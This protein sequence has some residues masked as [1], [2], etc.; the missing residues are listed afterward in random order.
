[1]SKGVNWQ[2]FFA[3]RTQKFRIDI[4]KENART[5][6]I[7]LLG[8]ETPFVTNEDASDNFFAPIRPQTGTISVCTK[9]ERQGAYPLGGTLKLEDIIPEN[10]IDR[11]VKVWNIT[12]PSSPYLEWQGFL[13]CEVYSQEYT[14]IPQ[15]IDLPVISVL[16]AMDSV[17]VE[18]SESMAFQRILSHCIYAMKAIETKS[19]M[20][21]FNTVFLD[22][23]CQYET[24]ANYFYNNVYFDADEQISGDNIVVEVH[25][26][27][28]KAIL[29]QVAKFFGCCWREASGQ[30]IYF[31]AVGKTAF[32]TYDTFTNIYNSLIAGTSTLNLKS[33]NASTANLSD[34]KW[35]GNGH[36][37]SVTQG[38]RRV[39]V[40]SKL[41]D[42]E[43]KMSLEE[44]P[45]NDL[46]ENPEARQSANGEVHVNTN[47][48]FYSLADHKHYLTRAIFP[49][50]LSG[51]S[52][53]LTSTLS[54][55]NYAHTIFW[56]TSEFRQY[57]Y[58]LVNSQTKG[59]NRGLNHY[60]TSFMAWWRDME[61]E[62]QSGLMIC[63]V[64]KH[65]YFASG[66]VQGRIWNKYAL[67]ADNYLFRQRTPLIFAATKGFIKI[68][69]NT[70]AWSNAPGTM[71]SLVYG[72][73]VYPTLTIALQL[74]N[75]WAY[76][77]GDTYKWSSTFQT[78]DFPL[79]HKTTNDVLK[80][81]GNWDESMGI[82]EQEGIFIEIPE[83]MV[84]IV[85]IRVYPFVD[86]ICLDPYDNSM[87]DVF[88]N[89]MDV[90]YVPLKEELLTDRS[91]N[92]YATETSQAFRDE[93]SLG[94]DLAS[95]A[96][97]TKLATMVWQS[98][99]VTPVKLMNLDGASVRPEVNLLNRLASFY[100]AA[101]QRLELEV[102]HP[103]DAPLPLL[104]LNGINDGKVYLPLSESRDWQTDVCK[105]TCF[106][107]P[108]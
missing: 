81:L 79:E 41:D 14:G 12:N 102:A 96:N 11:P 88:I 17:E 32:Y 107:M 39:K 37:R 58:D 20:S 25:S 44:C 62:L 95:Y 1:M 83:F 105:L 72:E 87:F 82:D 47:E 23:H 21:L 68:D 49:T 70:L 59:S 3:S 53:Q 56:K 64:P 43:C 13:S 16:E 5:N 30:N 108:Q 97:N 27:S 74:G 61:N 92:V 54:G 66:P 46:V 78:I 29:E 67:T 94:V 98:D 34:Q 100:G 103:T 69:I 40:T 99:G 31:E 65:L 35:M 51:A 2:I 10:N 9:I 76:K 18:L 24:I 45:V 106:E 60:I 48:T 50:D 36:Q 22:G 8:G 57:Y 91:E 90:E 42:F 85:S 86:A 73:A 89:K 84:G 15:N 28:C 26:I 7:Q 63:G 101:R 104:K 33:V 77:D 55:I 80:T 38:M 93:L 19:G 71:P 52:L 6:P 75:K 4:Y